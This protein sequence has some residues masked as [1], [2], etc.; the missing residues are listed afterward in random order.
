MD[1]TDLPL[2]ALGLSFSFSALAA[3]FV[4]GIVGFYI[5]RHGKRSLNYPLIFTGIA[6]MSYTL[7]TQG[8]LQD[9][10]GG[11]LL[12]GLAYYFNKNANQTG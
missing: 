2:D 8:P 12:C 5:F 1:E 6:L 7:F 3:G 11:A 9:W 10:G 4:F